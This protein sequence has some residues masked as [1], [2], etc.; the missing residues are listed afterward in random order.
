MPNLDRL[1]ACGLRYNNFHV[2]ALCSPTRVALLTGRNH[3]SANAGAVM[4]IATAYPGNNGVRPNSI[5]P[6]AEILRLPSCAATLHMEFTYDGGGRGKGG[7][8]TLL[9]N[10]RK[11]AEGRIANTIPNGFSTDEGVSVASTKKRWSRATTRSLTT[12]SPV[13][14]ARSSSRS[15]S[16]FSASARHPRQGRRR[17][18]GAAAHGESE[19]DVV[20]PG[21]S[22]RWP[23]VVAV[24]DG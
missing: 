20:L 7:V 10:G 16:Y 18:N 19:A 1:A 9:V 12:V 6:L 21:L 13:N 14:S 8:A 22:R 15:S 17:A 3:H 2:A 11:V 23:I 24:V 4:D 5:V